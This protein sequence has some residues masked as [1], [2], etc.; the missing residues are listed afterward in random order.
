MFLTPTLPGDLLVVAVVGL[1]GWHFLHLRD[2]HRWVLLD[3]LNT[4]WA[5]ILV[6]YVGQPILAGDIFISWHSPAVFE[7]TLLATVV[8]LVF[9][10]AGYEARLGVDLAQKIPRLP[11]A[12]SSG[13]LLVA[14]VA[15]ILLGLWGY[16][17]VIRLSGGLSQ[18]LSIGRGGTDFHKVQGYLPELTQALPAGVSILMVRAGVSRISWPGKLVAWSAGAA[19]WWWFLYLGSRSRLIMFSVIMVAAYYLP[20]RKSPHLAL[21]G[22]FVVLMFPVVKLQECYRDRFTNLSLNLGSLDK[23]E[24]WG[25]IL[26]VSIGGDRELY[27]SQISP[28]SEFNCA[29][30]VVDLVPSRVPYNYGYG[31]LEIFTRPVPRLLWPQKPYPHSESVQ[32]VLREA[33]LAESTVAAV[34]GKELLMGPAF[35]FVGH[36]YYVGGFVGLMI[37]GLT[38]GVLLRTI[39]SFHDLNPSN[40]GMI[41]IYPFLLSIGFAEAA[42]TPWYWFYTLPFVLLPFLVVIYCA[43]KLPR[44]QARPLSARR[45]NTPIP[46]PDRAA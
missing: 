12:L 29:M 26:P 25:R 16:L 19:M 24:M 23:R 10:L 38:T 31:F 6:C 20:R 28:G 22:L 9:V 3:P 27:R 42:S 18:W 14:A 32:G 7:K 11:A 21:L 35:C 17:Y 5:G 37:G 13:K 15:L 34:E 33:G 39:R 41:I 36:W 4:F 43:R 45:R 1:M 46:S 44:H 40:Q 2:Q 30:S 8:G